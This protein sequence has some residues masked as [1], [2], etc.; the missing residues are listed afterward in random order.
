[1]N[2]PEQTA[3]KKVWKTLLSILLAVAF[4]LPWLIWRENI[5]QYAAAGYGGLF[6]TCLLINAV[7]LL[8]ASS[9]ICVVVASTVLNPVICVAVATVGA[10]AGEMCAYLCGTIGAANIRKE[11]LIDRFTRWV[12]K[13]AFLSVLICAAV[14]LP[15]FD[16][17]GLAAG[18]RRMPVWQYVLAVSIGKGVKYTVTVLTALKLVPWM[19]QQLPGYSSEMAQLLL[20]LIGQEVP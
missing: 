9:T 5:Q 14:P 17:V 4:A 13:R 20:K 3:G 10:A 12:E 19:A 18:A 7:V 11:G 8:P 15:L 1:M 16:V 2:T 6:L